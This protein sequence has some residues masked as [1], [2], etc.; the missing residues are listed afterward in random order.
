VEA[1]GFLFRAA[2]YG[3]D[4]AAILA[5]DGDGERLMPLAMERCS[6]EEARERLRA[7]SAV[8]LFAGARAPEAAPSGLYVYFSCFEEAHKIAQDI[9][10]AEGSYWHAIVHR[11][12]PD[13]GNAAYWFRQV[14]THPIFPALARAAGQE[15]RWDPFAFIEMCEQAR[16]QPGSELEARA[17]A[18]QRVEWQLLFDYCARP[19]VA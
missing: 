18:I 16:R 19:A 15:G 1:S 12:E 7:A 10:T 4:V 13:A 11:Q 5:L 2:D 6:S 8:G 14:G 9:P 3:S 17:R